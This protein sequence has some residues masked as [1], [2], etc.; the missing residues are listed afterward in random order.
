MSRYLDMIRI[1][2]RSKIMFFS[3]NIRGWESFLLFHSTIN[4]GYVSREFQVCFR[5]V[6]GVARVCF[7][8]G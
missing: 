1:L 8:R 4:L 2:L 5:R 7:R 3:L 6:S